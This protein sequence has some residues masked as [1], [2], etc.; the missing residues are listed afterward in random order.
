[1]IAFSLPP[2]TLEIADGDLAAEIADAV[3]NA[4]NNELWMGAGVAGA[5]KARGGQAIEA[6]AMA[7]GPVEPGQCVI[8][9]GGRLAARH[10]IHAAVMG[11]DLRTSAA[12][13]AEATRNTLQLADAR[14]LESIAFPAFGTGVGGFPLDDCAR[15]MIDSIRAHA[16]GAGSVRRVRLVLFGQAAYRAFAD[17]AGEMLGPPL[18]G[19]P[20]CPISG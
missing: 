11:Q 3:V 6:E 4:A 14:R 18:D 19:D 20:D 12:L 8:T 13:I 9:G 16:S 2:L 17:V 5:L 10:V 7:Q 1:L 15:L